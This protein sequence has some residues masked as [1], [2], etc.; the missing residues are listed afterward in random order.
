VT[1]QEKARPDR[2]RAGVR[3]RSLALFGLGAGC[4]AALGIWVAYGQF[5]HYERRALAHVPVGAELVARLDVEKVPLFEPVRRHLLPLIDKLPLLRTAP[6]DAL[7][8]E[9][10]LARLRNLGFNIAVDLREILIADV[11]EPPGWVVVLGGIYDTDGFVPTVEAVLRAEAVT[12]VTRVGD[13]LR[14][15]PSGAMLG[16]A[17]D[18][19]LI[20]ASD[21]ATLANAL[22]ASEHS[23]SLGLTATGAGELFATAAWLQNGWARLAQSTSEPAWL[24]L[25]RS[26]GITLRLGSDLHLDGRLEAAS[27]EQAHELESVLERWRQAQQ[28]TGPS[29]PQADWGGERA[30]LARTQIGQTN[31]SVVVFSSSWERAEFDRAVRSLASWV[32]RRFAAP[33]PGSN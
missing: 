10:R 18:G 2:V 16:Q 3:F 9:G 6:S 23:A 13:T 27:P 19:S 20:V 29:V 21:P 28:L 4:V 26:I 33:S 11:S 7:S 5:I 22:P 12:G 25:L 15:A 8:G 1:E 30:V 32:E 24:G 14:F 31:D 17:A